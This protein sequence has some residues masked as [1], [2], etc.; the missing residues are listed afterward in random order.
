PLGIG[1]SNGSLSSGD[2]SSIAGRAFAFEPGGG[3]PVTTYKG[4]GFA[5]SSFSGDSINTGGGNVLINTH[6]LTSFAFPSNLDFTST[7]RNIAASGYVSNNAA[8]SFTLVSGSATGTN[9]VAGKVGNT[10]T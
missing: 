10:T 9:I 1:S 6:S 3:T 7:A 5:S 4:T 2:L 8:S